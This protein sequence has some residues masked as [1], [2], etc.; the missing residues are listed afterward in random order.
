VLP[1]LLLLVLTLVA[2]PAVQAAGGVPRPHPDLRDVADLDALGREAEGRGV[3]ILL[4]V[5][6]TSCPYCRRLERDV[7]VPTVRSG[8]YA[9]TLVV[10][11]LLVD[12]PERVVDFQGRVRDAGEIARDYRVNVVPTL[13]LLAPDGSLLA[14]PIVGYTT[15]ELYWGYVAAAIETARERLGAARR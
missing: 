14:E 9:S 10:A 15:P 11:R 2:L 7:L 8:E 4:E 6:S 12:Q 5:A 13:L 3:P 1:R